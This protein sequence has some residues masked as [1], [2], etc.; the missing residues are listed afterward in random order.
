MNTEPTLTG[1]ELWAWRRRLGMTQRELAECLGTSQQTVHRWESEFVAIKH[2]RMMRLAL[3]T[4]E[5]AERAK[6]RPTA[7]QMSTV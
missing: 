2:P 4:L 3:I 6:T 1:A 7:P 5:A